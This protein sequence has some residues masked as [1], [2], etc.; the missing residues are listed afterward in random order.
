MEEAYKLTERSKLGEENCL[1]VRRL[2]IGRL[3]ICVS[4]IIQ[5][6]KYTLL[7]LSL[8]LLSCNNYGKTSDTQKE[9]ID[10]FAEFEY[11]VEL[12]EDKQYEKAKEKFLILEK[13]APELV[14]I[15]MNLSIIEENNG[16][17]EQ[18]VEYAEKALQL[19]PNNVNIVRYLEEWTG[20]EEY[21]KKRKQLENHIVKV[22]APTYFKNFQNRSDIVNSEYAN[23]DIEITG[24][25]SI[26]EKKEKTIW[27]VGTGN[28]K[29]EGV[30]CVKISDSE[31]TD[32]SVGD[33]VT[34]I[35][36]SFGQGEDF[37]KAL[38][39]YKREAD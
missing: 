20:D 3:Y 34:F 30:E 27:L 37:D 5:G 15:K 17:I 36:F 29:E 21:T 1:I 11:A 26:K 7:V 33:T 2:W 25:V 23:F 16:N 24:I 28:S 8:T 38:I 18:A 32:L 39:V 19:A 14:G 31:F 6:M 4:S 12:L 22:D 35:G 9:D 10:V 13:L